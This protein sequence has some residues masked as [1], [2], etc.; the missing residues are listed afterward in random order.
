MCVCVCVCETSATIKL[1]SVCEMQL[2]CHNIVDVGYF[3]RNIGR[4]MSLAYEFDIYY[5]LY[6][7][8]VMRNCGG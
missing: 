3:G 4:L 6:A 7:M 8:F 1:C 5:C 2:M